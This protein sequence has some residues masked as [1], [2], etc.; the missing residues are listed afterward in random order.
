MR[1]LAALFFQNL[2]GLFDWERELEVVVEVVEVRDEKKEEEDPAWVEERTRKGREAGGKLKMSLELV[3]K[4]LGGLEEEEQ[5][6]LVESKTREEDGFEMGGS[7]KGGRWEVQRE[8]V[9]RFRKVRV[10]VRE[11]VVSREREGRREVA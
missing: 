9:W 10:R 11:V 8:E 5:L 3:G 7:P 2:E 6:G 1:P 4:D